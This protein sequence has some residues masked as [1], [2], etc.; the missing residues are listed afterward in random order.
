MTE[1][2]L[3]DTNI[4]LKL[5]EKYTFESY[6]PTDD[7]QRKALNLCRAYVHR[8][9]AG[10]YFTGGVGSGK[11]HLAIAI[12]VNLIKQGKGV[13]FYRTTDLLHAIRTTFRGNDINSDQIRYAIRFAPF[14]IIDDLGAER[15]TEWVAETF[16][17]LI[18]Y[19]YLHA[20]RFKTIITSNL[21]LGQVAQRMED[22]RISSRLTEICLKV[23][24]GD[25]DYRLKKAP[26]PDILDIKNA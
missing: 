25:V 5:A 6:A 21:S 12:G 8:P 13:K 7:K 10:L 26:K 19:R 2:D 11:T 23:D 16:Y 1:N 20:D 17:D 22:P 14:L 9:V 4:P 3:K 15:L 18:D 24:T